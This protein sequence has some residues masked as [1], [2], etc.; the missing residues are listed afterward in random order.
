MYP[1]LLENCITQFLAA[2]CSSPYTWLA[3][4]GAQ[5]TLECDSSQ[6][7]WWQRNT[8][9]GSA[10]C[11]ELQQDDW[12]QRHACSN[13]HQCSVGVTSTTAMLEYC[14]TSG[15]NPASAAAAERR[16]FNLAS[17]C[18]SNKDCVCPNTVLSF[19][20]APK[21]PL[22]QLCPPKSSLVPQLPST[23]QWLHIPPLHLTIQNCGTSSTAQYSSS[24]PLKYPQTLTSFI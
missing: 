18:I 13:S 7:R 1:R 3:Y 11:G 17:K 5:R 10:E 22:R 14:C 6:N 16:C 8:T 15:A 12:V 2:G 4:N 19:Q 23:S 21:S 9:Q 20:F 24:F